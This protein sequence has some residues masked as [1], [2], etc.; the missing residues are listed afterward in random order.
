VTADPHRRDK[1]RTPLAVGVNSGESVERP[2]KRRTNQLLSESDQLLNFCRMKPPAHP[3]SRFGDPL[4]LS[5]KHFC[6]QEIRSR[7]IA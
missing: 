6:P 7:G 1:T 3:E 5:G 2:Y 4:T